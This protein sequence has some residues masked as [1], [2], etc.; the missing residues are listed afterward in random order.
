MLRIEKI[1]SRCVLSV[2]VL[3]LMLSFPILGAPKTTIRMW[4][5]LNPAGT[6]GR[7][8]ALREI[9]SRFERD[10]PDIKVVVEPQQW[11][12]MTAKF[13]AAHKVGN[14]PDVIWVAPAELGAAIELGAL[15]DFESLFLKNW[16]ADEIA[17]IDDVFWH[18]GETDGKHYQITL[19]RNY[20]ALIYREDLLREKGIKT[21]FKTWDELIDAAKK[22][23]EVDPKTGIER[24]GLG[25]AFGTEKVDPPL[26]VPALLSTQGNLFTK[27]GEAN[28]STEAGIGAMNLLIDMVKTHRITPE[29]A[30]GY[31]VEDMY[32][33]FCAGKY[34]MISAAAVRVPNLREQASF[35]GS[36]IQMMHWPNW[37]DSDYSPGVALGWAV[38]VWSKSKNKEAAGKFV[39]H[40]FSGESD[41]LWVTK[42][43]QAPV[44]KS[45]LESARGFFDDPANSYLKVMSEGFAKYGWLEPWTYRVSGWAM[46]LNNAIQSILVKGVGVT[47]ALKQAENEFNSRNIR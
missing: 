26:L 32:Q 16:S 29:G 5:F 22:L 2:V 1:W 41:E 25:Q 6:S 3:L 27:D 36:T 31:S 13:F 28:W 44:R 34:A 10:N 14:A 12:M 19:S 23:T 43:G 24:W 39:E 11:D 21:P 18:W 45:T 46:D 42:G 15:A 7:E 40:L 17:D 8:V 37:S 20:I 9:I 35:D 38:G 33:D 30:V 4:T 47:D